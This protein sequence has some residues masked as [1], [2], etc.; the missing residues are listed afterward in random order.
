MG[1]RKPALC[2][3]S[4]TLLFCDYLGTGLETMEQDRSIQKNMI[5]NTAG[6]LIYYACQWSMSV[7]IVHLSGYEAAGILAIAMTV[8]ASPAIVSLFNVRSYQVS[9]IDGQYTPKTYIRSRKYTNLL[10]YL[11]CICMVLVGGYNLEKASVILTF[12]LYKLAEGTADVYYGIEQRWG[13]LD[14]AGISMTLRGIG[15]IVSFVLVQHFLGNLLL[16]MIAITVCSY[17]VILLYDR[18]KVRTWT[19]EEPEAGAPAAGGRNAV[20]ASSAEAQS[21]GRSAAEARRAQRNA[22]WKLLVTCVP[23][24]VV[25]FLNNFSVNLPKIALESNFGSEVMGY[26]SSVTSPTLVVQMAASTIFAPLVTPLTEAFS[27]KDKSAFYGLLGKFAILLSVLAV[28]CLA[29]AAVLGRWVLNFLFGAKIDP[30]VYL[31]IPGI[32]VSVLL[33]IN[34]SLFSVCTLIR[35]IKKQYLVG[36]M[37]IVVSA[38]LAFTVVPGFSMNGVIYAQMGTMAVQIL[39]QIL[40][41]TRKLNRS[42]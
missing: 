10:A 7:L 37:G 17:A 13:R 23:L 26:F 40:L 38:G 31:F 16:S 14:Y 2:A 12:M 3:I 32:L 4:E 1:L 39:I 15:T 9:D 29:G 41:I 30:Y 28:L 5:F 6:S 27:R 24:A 35:E 18:R 21:G 42:W 20:S 22:V 36:I 34:A 11:V 25:A 33:A 8:C 19:A